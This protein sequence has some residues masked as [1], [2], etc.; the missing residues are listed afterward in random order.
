MAEIR[1][2]RQLK[3]RRT[4]QTARRGLLLIATVSGVAAA[5]SPA[6]PT[7][8]RPADV[9]WCALIGAAFPLI[10]SRS[11]RWPLLWTGWIAAV[12]GVGG[13][14]TGKIGTIALLVVLVLMTF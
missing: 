10:A 12:V 5:L 13:D 9:L 2:T 8:S 11:K 1:P 7:G 4:S 6:R 14:I 3:Y